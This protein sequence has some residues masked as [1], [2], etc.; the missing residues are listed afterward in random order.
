[1]PRKGSPLLKIC[2]SS[3]PPTPTTP[4]RPP[5]LAFQVRTY[6][7]RYSTPS[8]FPKQ[9]QVTA[10]GPHLQGVLPQHPKAVG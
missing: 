9:Q 10:V 2:T 4:S 5:S 7:V 3:P 6:L 1:M 8:P